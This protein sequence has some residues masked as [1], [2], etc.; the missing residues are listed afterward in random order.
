MRIMELLRAERTFGPLQV[1]CSEEA[2]NKDLLR[3]GIELK[4]KSAYLPWNIYDLKK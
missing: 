2:H 4:I 3:E 1:C